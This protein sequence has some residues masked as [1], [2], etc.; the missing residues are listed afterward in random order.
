MVES[1]KQKQNQI[2]VR[3]GFGA[4]KCSRPRVSRVLP[5]RIFA[6][7]PL[8]LHQGGSRLH[9]DLLS[10]EHLS[11]NSGEDGIYSHALRRE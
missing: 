4:Y 1:R 5:L 3:D 10:G 6:V 2:S 9:S 7:E 8:G 11:R